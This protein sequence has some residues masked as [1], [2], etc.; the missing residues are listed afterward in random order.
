MM[1]MRCGIMQK[2]LSD[3]FLMISELSI[4]KKSVRLHL[5]GPKL[6]VNVKPAIGNE[7]TLS[8]CQ[9]DFCAPG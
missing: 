5:Y 4:Q 2:T 8:T 7:Y 6:D 9:L 1:M 3:V